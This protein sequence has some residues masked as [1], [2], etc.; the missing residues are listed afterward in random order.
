MIKKRNKDIN[1]KSSGQQLFTP[2]C[3]DPAKSKTMADDVNATDVEFVPCSALNSSTEE[4]SKKTLELINFLKVHELTY[5]LPSVTKS[6]W[7]NFF[8]LII[9]K[10]VVS[11]I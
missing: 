11:S 2:M 4:F 3:F 7:I 6:Q 5:P 8:Q 10:Q 1:G 9:R